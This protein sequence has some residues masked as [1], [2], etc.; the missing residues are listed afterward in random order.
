MHVPQSITRKY[1]ESLL[2]MQ[3]EAV[4]LQL[5]ISRANQAKF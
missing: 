3:N 4:E 1:T 5:H 2:V